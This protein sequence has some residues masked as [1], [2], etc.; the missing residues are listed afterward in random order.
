[1]AKMIPSVLPSSVKSDAEKKIFDWFKNAPG[2]DDWIVLYSVMELDHPTLIQGET[3]FL[4]LAPQLGCFALE[5][6]GGRVSRDGEGMWCFTDKNG[7]TTKKARGPYEQASEGMYAIKKFLSDANPEGSQN[8]DLAGTFFGY[9]V[10]FPDIYFDNNILGPGEAVE[11]VFDLSFGKN[12]IK[13][14]Q[15]LSAFW[16]E[17]SKNKN[18]GYFNLNWLPTIS[19]CERLARQLRKSFDLIPPLSTMAEY[20]EKKLLSLTEEEYDAID[21]AEDNLHN[22]FL[23][24]AGTGKTLIALEQARRSQEDSI[25]IICYNKNLGEWKKAKVEG[26]PNKDKISYVGTLH[27]LVIGNIKAAHLPLDFDFDEMEADAAALV[28]LFDQSL[29]T[30]P[31]AF[32]QIIVDEVQD[33]LSDNYLMIFDL[34]LKRG[35]RH[36]RF[37]F[38]GDFK[39]QAIYR[40]AFINEEDAMDKL[41][42]YCSF[43][44]RKL[45]KNCRNT[46]EICNQI[47]YIT[48]CWYK[49]KMK[50][51]SGIE[52]RFFSDWDDDEQTEANRIK[53]EIYKLTAEGIRRSEIVILSPYKRDNS[54]ARFLNDVAEYGSGNAKKVNFATIHSFK[55]LESEAVILCDMDGYDTDSNRLSLL[56][57]GLSRARTILIVFETQEA[58]KQRVALMFKNKDGGLHG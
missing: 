9:G 57:V 49:K 14:I 20:A 40:H 44:R 17:K 18:K 41:N 1:M 15:G 11:E 26:F 39:N 31:I 22:V 36:G 24:S 16:V 33:L 43:S 56:Y 13:Y 54:C 3:D 35:L 38:F 37:S 50:D 55:G 29:K 48:G 10:M 42:E 6:K 51:P 47:G 30:H 8:A 2:T 23:G 19:Q 21:E 5:V 27:S 52:V 7:K 46:P 53:E 28:D 34:L 45:L 58:M 25:A 12:V 4:V 32:D